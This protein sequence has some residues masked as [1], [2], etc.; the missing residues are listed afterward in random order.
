MLKILT[1]QTKI[2]IWQNTN[3]KVTTPSIPHIYKQ[4]GGHLIVS[5]I[6]NFESIA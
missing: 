6:Q 2:V 5:P 1:A 4:D 3:F